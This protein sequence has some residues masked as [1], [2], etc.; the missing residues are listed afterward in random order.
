MQVK[1]LARA[2]RF[3]HRQVHQLVQ[4]GHTDDVEHGLDV[5]VARA[6]MAPDELVLSGGEG[7][8][9]CHLGS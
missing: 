3:G 2:N 6:D 8:G 1:G 9:D 5:G 7:F 4:A